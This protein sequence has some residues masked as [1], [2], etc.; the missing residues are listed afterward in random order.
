MRDHKGLLSKNKIGDALRCLGFNP[1]K[2]E[3]HVISRND[4]LI[5]F[6]LDELSGQKI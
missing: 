2:K 4:F 3:V 6:S 1:L 5:N